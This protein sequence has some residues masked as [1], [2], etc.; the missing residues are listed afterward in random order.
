MEGIDDDT[1]G[2]TVFYLNHL[3]LPG[4]PGVRGSSEV[5]FLTVFIFVLA[6]L[7]AGVKP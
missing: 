2:V 7:L 1:F 4:D 6:Y 5:C 3:L